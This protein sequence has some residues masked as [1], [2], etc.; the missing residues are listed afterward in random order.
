MKLARIPI[1]PGARLR[2]GRVKII[3]IISGRVWYDNVRL[4]TVNSKECSYLRH[5]VDPWAVME[6]CSL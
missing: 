5:V 1:A 2:L 3:L 4:S 6:T